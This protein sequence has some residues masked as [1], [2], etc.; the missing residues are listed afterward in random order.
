MANHLDYFNPAQLDA[1]IKRGYPEFNTTNVYYNFVKRGGV[2]KLTEEQAR[3]QAKKWYNDA[4]AVDDGLACLK[5]CRKEF[6]K[7]GANS[8][9]IANLFPYEVLFQ[10]AY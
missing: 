7:S 3:T 5:Q 9:E 4:H 10:V 1:D 8:Q 2:A 6:A